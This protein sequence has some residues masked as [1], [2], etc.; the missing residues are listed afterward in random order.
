[1]NV[2]AEINGLGWA[3]VLSLAALLLLF[4]G[5]LG[6]ARAFQEWGKR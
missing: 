4:A 3:V 5:L 6:V 2:S 1:M